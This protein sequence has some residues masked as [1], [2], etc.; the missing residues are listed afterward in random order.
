MIDYFLNGLYAAIF[1]IGFLAGL[2][3]LGVAIGALVEIGKHA[4]AGVKRRLELF[5]DEDGE[6]V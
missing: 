2:L 1:L 4:Y 3:L 5:P 6:G